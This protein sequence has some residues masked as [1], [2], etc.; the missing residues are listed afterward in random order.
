MR[1]TLFLFHA[2]AGP[3]VNGILQLA[4]S[5]DSL[6]MGCFVYLAVAF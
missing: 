1:V 2:H 4:Q 6:G 5:Y 3:T